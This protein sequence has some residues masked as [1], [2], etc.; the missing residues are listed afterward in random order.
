MLCSFSSF[1]VDQRHFYTARKIAIDLLDKES[2]VMC[3]HDPYLPQNRSVPLMYEKS[4]FYFFY[5]FLNNVCCSFWISSSVPDSC[6][7]NEGWL[8]ISCSSNLLPQQIR[9]HPPAESYYQ[10]SLKRLLLTLC[11]ITESHHCCSC[12]FY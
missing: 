8:A 6:L 2:V 1:P 10:R 9:K 11:I 12:N 5:L 3:Y 7:G 4:V